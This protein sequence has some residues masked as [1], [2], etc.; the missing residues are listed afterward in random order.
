MKSIADIKA[1]VKFKWDHHNCK[2]A[3]G[4]R[5]TVN[6]DGALGY[7]SKKIK[8]RVTLP[9]NILAV[10]CGKDGNIRTRIKFNPH[11]RR[12]LNNRMFTRYFVQFDD[13]EIIGIHS[14]HLDK[15]NCIMPL[16]YEGWYK[17]YQA[18]ANS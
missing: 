5:V 4:D 8:D 9:G 10:S 16:E 12:I 15:S 3:P 2:F 13:G 11:G 7:N 1:N 14:H 17:C 6:S 18:I